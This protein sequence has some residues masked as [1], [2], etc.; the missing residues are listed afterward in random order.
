MNCPSPA[1]VPSRLRPQWPREGVMVNPWRGEVE[2]VINGEP[3]RMRLTLGALAELEASLDCGSLM[4][5][6]ERFETG[7]FG[8]RDISALLVAGLRGAG[9]RGRAD[10]LANAE[11]AGGPM[12]A[13][14]AAALLLSR[15]FELPEGD[16]DV[17]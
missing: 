1:P 10:Q 8:A 9:W 2:L 17:P 12:A 7:Q 3:H 16:S 6:V 5:L 13:A 14:K 4:A 11:I 15:A